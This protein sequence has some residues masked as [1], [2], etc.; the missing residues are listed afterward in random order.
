[1]KRTNHPEFS[2]DLATSPTV[3][4]TKP[5]NRWAHFRRIWPVYIH[6]NLP[7]PFGPDFFTAQLVLKQDLCPAGTKEGFLCSTEA[8]KSYIVQHKKSP[9]LHNKLENPLLAIQSSL[10]QLLFA[11]AQLRDGVWKVCSSNKNLKSRQIRIQFR[12]LYDQYESSNHVGK[13]AYWDLS[14]CTC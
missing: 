10:G 7:Q 5:I 9:L 1:M 13:G 11:T 6:W 4:I 3:T 2:S 8:T 12:S 14:W